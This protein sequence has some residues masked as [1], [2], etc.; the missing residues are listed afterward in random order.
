V[1]HS[2]EAALDVEARVAERRLR[3]GAGLI[4]EPLELL[5]RAHLAHP[6]SSATGPRLQHHGIADRLRDAQPFGHRLHR[7]VGAGDHRQPEL[8]HRDARRDLVVEAP[9]D[10]GGRTDEHEPVFLADLG[11]VGV[12]GQEPVPRMDRLR[13]ADERGRHDR[14]DVHVALARR[15]GSDTDRFVGEVHRKAMRVGLAVHEHGLD[16]ELAAGADHAQRDL[17][18]IRD[19]DLIEGQ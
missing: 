7:A 13:A 1:P 19:E 8:L 18:S 2:L 4:P 16:P 10:F 11:E 9:E 15:R 5:R 12:L 6:A 3:L 14:R 17:A